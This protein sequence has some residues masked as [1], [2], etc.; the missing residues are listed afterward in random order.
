[1]GYSGWSEAQLMDEIKENT[2]LVS[3]KYH[4]D[5]IFSNNEEELWKEMMI[6]LGPKYAHVGNFP[7]DP[8]LN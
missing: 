6:N 8:S 3:E 1:M 5:P 4:T 7:I 2:W